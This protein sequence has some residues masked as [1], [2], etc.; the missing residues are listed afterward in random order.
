MILIRNSHLLLIRKSIQ[1]NGT[2]D[3][4]TSNDCKLFSFHKKL[5]TDFM[6]VIGINGSARKVWN[7]ETLVKKALEGA[8]DAG[9]EVELI[10]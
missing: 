3:I 9:A 10:E 1:P 2:F 5:N 4:Q 8:A 7:T 6:K